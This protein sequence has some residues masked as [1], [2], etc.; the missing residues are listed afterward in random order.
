[1]ENVLG[2]GLTWAYGM[3]HSSAKTR[4][5]LAPTVNEDRPG[6]NAMLNLG[7]FKAELRASTFEM[8][9]RALSASA[10]DLRPKARTF[11]P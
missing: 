1:M 7:D 2:K 10:K 3:W 8:I 5:K 6:F 9:D 11:K 4:E